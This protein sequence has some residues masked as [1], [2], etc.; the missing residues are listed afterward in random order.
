MGP[1]EQP[2]VPVVAGVGALSTDEACAL[3][4]GAAEAGC[5]GLMVLP[6]YV[7]STD[8]REMRAHVA[9]VIETTPLPCM[10]YNN[11]IAYRTDFR[12]EHVAE[13]AR[14]HAN[15]A[16]VKESSADIRRI[17]A[18]R[19]ALGDRLRILVGVEAGQPLAQIGLQVGLAGGGDAVGG[20]L[21]DEQMRRGHHQAGHAAGP[22]GGVQQGDGA[23]VAVAEQPGRVALGVQS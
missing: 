18:L 4:R 11:P 8:W 14:A 22:G 23:A 15:L 12:P 1:G 2:D 17:A 16:A 21:L 9:A 10:L 6:P 13:L 3:A 7:Y 19:H 20:E 5:R